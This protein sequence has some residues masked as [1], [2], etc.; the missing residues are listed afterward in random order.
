MSKVVEISPTTRHKGH[1]KLT[2]KVNDQGIVERRDWLSIT[3]V[4]G[5]EKLA[6]GKTMDQVPKIASR[7]CGVCPIAHCL[8][9]IEAMEASIGCEIPTDANLLRVI[10]HAANHTHSHALH[11]ILILP[12][13]Y[14]P[15]TE[16][17][18]TRSSR[19][20]LSEA[21]RRGSSESERSGR[22]LEP[23]RAAK[24]LHPSN[25]RVGGMCFRSPGKGT[26][27]GLQPPYKTGYWFVRNLHA[28]AF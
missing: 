7:V 1:S 11:N 28:R 27:R 3:P 21:L 4:R 10:L 19:S 17:R 15:G 25:P 8:A 5:I 9:S 16:R 22:P 14:I 23:S 6:I 24:A 2:L 13:F 12:D 20:G 26:V 18:S